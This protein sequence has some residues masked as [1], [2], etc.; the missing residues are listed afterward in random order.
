MGD[1]AHE[2]EFR[3]MYSPLLARSRV[4]GFR[5]TT[6]RCARV[7]LVVTTHVEAGENPQVGALD[8][9]SGSPSACGVEDPHHLRASRIGTT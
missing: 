5:L 6:P 3:P 1:Q 4:G 9:R 2:R 8:T 7:D